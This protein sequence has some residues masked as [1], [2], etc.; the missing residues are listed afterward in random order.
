MKILQINAVYNKASTGRTCKELHDFLTEN[1]HKCITVYGGSCADWE[2]TFHIGNLLDYKIH[3]LLSRISGK[4]GYYSLISTIR[5]IQYIKHTAPDIVH[6]RVLHSNFINIPLLLK[7]L[8]KEDIPTV[9]TLHDCFFFTGKCCHYTDINC[10]KWKTECKACPSYKNWN[11]SW[12]F[13]RTNKMFLDKKYLFD[14]IEKLAVVGVS[15]WITSEA[16]QSY[17]FKDRNISTI[18]NW[19]DTS[20]FTPVQSKV[21]DL[22]GI[23]AKIMLLGVA[24]D[25]SE[26]KGLGDFIK[27]AKILPLE[28]YAI[29]L[30]GNIP[31]TLGLPENIISIKQT[32]STMELAEYY[33][34]ADIFLQLSRQETFGK[35]TAESLSCGTPVITYG[36]TANRE[37]AFPGCGLCVEKTGDVDGVLRS[38]KFIA[39]QGKAYYSENCRTTAR[40]FFE[41]N[42][43][44]DMYVNLY[45]K[46]CS[47]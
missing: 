32:N 8:G 46:L 14:L 43:N 28:Q 6:L 13:D 44:C 40:K 15:D 38:I 16:R 5:L 21:K 36:N 35:V 37:M 30:V 19:V 17:I 9:V 23:S 29:V 41:R 33:S 24:S 34:S 47:E 22:L 42:K 4:V 26:H 39:K 2:D 1:G 31:A 12:F 3:A 7:F 10:T 20:I 11:R 25:W 45:Q 18:Y 27:L